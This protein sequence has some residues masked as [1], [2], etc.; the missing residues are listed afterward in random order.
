MWVK[1][2]HKPFLDMLRSSHLT[3]YVRLE[4]FNPRD[5]RKNDGAHPPIYPVQPHEYSDVKG[6]IWDYVAR[7]YLANIVYGER[8][9]TGEG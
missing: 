2:D 1:V 7:R 6:E 8:S 3:N 9:L 5:G 4:S